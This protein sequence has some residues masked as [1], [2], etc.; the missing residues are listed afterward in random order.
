MSGF[1]RENEINGAVQIYPKSVIT[2]R[3]ITV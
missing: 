1:R 2:N 3:T